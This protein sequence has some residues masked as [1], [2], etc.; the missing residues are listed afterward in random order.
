MSSFSIPGF[1]LKAFV[2]TT[3]AEDLGEGLP[4]GG[5]DVTSESV[6]PADARFTGVMDSRDA[7]TVCGLPI[8]A[9]FFRALDPAMA[10]EIL[11]EEGARVA[12]GTHLM[13]LEGNARAMLTAERSALNTVQHLSGVAT[14]TRQYVDAMG[15]VKARLLDTR[16]TIPGL[17]HLEKYAVRTGGG[18]NHRMGLWDAA[19]IKDNHVLVAGGVAEAVRR[20]LA[21][22]VKDVICEVDHLDQIEPALAAGA[23]RLLLDNMGPDLL[24]QAVALIAGRV[25]CEASGGVRLDTIAAI[26]ASG[27]DYVSVG[28]LTQSAPAADIGLDFTPLG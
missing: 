15:N 28:R 3:L 19:M 12:P 2:S 10:I 27:V 22:G 21:A 23:T 6:I 17:R 25:P 4:G 9:A 24:R 8:A 1:D 13:R 26:A 18:A 7:I 20:A 11:V 5:H 14:L 16:K